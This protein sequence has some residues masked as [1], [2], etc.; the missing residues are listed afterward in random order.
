MD[1]RS[2]G[3][4]L[5]PQLRK[6][7]LLA[8]ER[9][10]AMVGEADLVRLIQAG[11]TQAIE[12]LGMLLAE[13]GLIPSFRNWVW[14]LS[15]VATSAATATALPLA[16]SLTL[17]NPLML[18]WVEE[19]AAD[20]I[21][22]I[23]ADTVW[24]IRDVL[25]EG[26]VRGIG[27]RAMGRQI[28]GVVGLLPSHAR[29]V[30]NYEAKMR[31]DGVPEK[32]LERNVETYRRRLLAWRAETIARTETMTASHAGL[33]E[34][35]KLARDQGRLPGEVRMQ[36]V[37]TEDDRLCERCAPLDGVTV[38]LGGVFEATVKGFPDG[39]PDEVTPG[40]ERRRKGGLRPGSGRE[41]VRDEGLEGRLVPLRRPI[42]VS[43]PPLHPNCRC[44]L[45]LAI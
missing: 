29:A 8:V 42:R 11:N 34:G 6:D 17:L 27:A 25:V 33:V 1:I 16:P 15:Q 41:P 37:V 19:H 35:W 36:W 38:A 14:T 30:V 28:R 40:S 39:M 43:H 12:S 26:T 13:R 5:E 10:R 24:A 23:A 45:I 44:T 3:D 9:A 22:G 18:R 31:E 4:A 7:F 20:L 32:T 21:T 2:I